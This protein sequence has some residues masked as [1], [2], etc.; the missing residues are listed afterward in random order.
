[1]S[2]SERSVRYH[3]RQTDCAIR[4]AY[5]RLAT[6]APAVANFTNCCNTLGIERR[7]CWKRPFSTGIT[8]ASKRSS[9]YLDPKRAYPASGRVV[10]DRI[11]LAAG[12]FVACAPPRLQVRGSG[13]SRL[14]VVFD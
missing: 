9:I 12:G 8:P 13:V 14:V 11:V 7:V 1:M 10:G 2:W 5:A 3:K 4:H 6:D